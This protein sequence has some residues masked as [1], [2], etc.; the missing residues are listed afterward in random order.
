ME[1]LPDLLTFN[2]GSNVDANNWPQRRKELAEAIIPHEFG[3]MPPEPKQID[4]V[5]RANSNIRHW[6]GVRYVTYEIRTQFAQDK[7][8]SLTLSLWIPSGDGPFP[9]LLDCDGCWRYFNDN[10]IQNVLARGNI[11]ASVDRTEA[12]ADNKTE[13][14]DTGLYRLF[15]DAEFGV[16]PA[17][18]W[19]IH[20]CVDALI[21]FPEVKT[22]A[23]AVTGHSRGG[24]TAI[25]AGATDE[26]IAITNPNNSGIG[27]AGLNQL[28]MEGSEVVAS[29]FRSG[30]IFWFGSEY[31][32]H[33]DRDAEL[34]YDNH[35]LHALVAPRGLLLTEAYEDHSANPAGTYAAAQSAL[36][37]YDLLGQKDGIGWAYRESGH[38]HMPEDY[39]ALLDF[40]DRHL[41]GRDLKRDFQR[42]LY[43][44]LGKILHTPQPSEST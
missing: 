21:T 17:W 24:K 32:A 19:A 13:Y 34:T 27:G 2:N 38:A 18:A 37:V 10:V 9:V 33:R 30:N 35:Y 36:K 20:R 28:K 23:I 25:L 40:M 22:D 4:I 41:H 39:T 7:E 14:R 1:I 11:A 15:P 8:L 26:R 29:F 42:K 44:E 16:C 12:A 6:P 43:P 3:G 31:A 5:R